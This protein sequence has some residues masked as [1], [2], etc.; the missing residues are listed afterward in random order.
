MEKRSSL[1]V[2]YLVM[3]LILVFIL[4]SYISPKINNVSYSQFKDLIVQKKINSVVVSSNSLRGFE[5]P[6]EGAKEPLFPKFAY[7]T[8]RV[9]DKDL[10][11]FLEQNKVD[12]IAENE[13][14]F[15][16][17][18]LSWVIPL[19]FFMLVWLWFMRR[20]GQ[21]GM[22]GIMTLGKSKAKI[23][24][25]RDVGITFDDVAGQDEAKQELMEILEFL[26]TPDKFTRLGARIPKGILLIGPPGTGKT[27]LAKAVAGESGVPF[28]S[29][30]GSDFIELFVGLGAARVRDLFEQAKL[31]AP[32]VI[33]IDELDALGKARGLGVMG[34]HDEREQTLNQLLAEMDGFAT[35]RG[36]IILAATNR[37]EILDPALLRPGRFDRQIL[38]DRPDLQGRIDILKIHTR[39]L[40]LAPGVD[41]EIIARRTSGFTGADLANLAN[42]AAL[43]TARKGKDR[44]GLQEIEEA[45]DRIIAGLEK[46][47]RHLNEKEKTIVAY[48]ETG[49]ALM[50]SSRPT[51]EKVHKIT[52]VPHGI[53]A[54]GFTL[55]LP[56]EDRYLMS[57]TE[58][59][60]KIDV[61]L[62][63]RA[64][65]EIIFGDVTTGAH[66]DLQKATD[67]ARS[68]VA[69]YGMNSALG[70]MTYQQPDNLFLQ[71]NGMYQPREISEQ[72]SRVI[73]EEVRKLIE[74]RMAEV[75]K[76]LC[77]QKGLLHF[78]AK[79][80]LE[81]ETLDSEEFK[82]LIKTGPGPDSSQAPEVPFVPVKDQCG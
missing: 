59:L 46:K 66:N 68:M 67:I 71:Q 80:L 12:I 55:Q 62:A 74:E 73:D 37:P 1:T 21:Q 39:Q 17:I 5:K 70:H 69:L 8:P 28:F 76:S 77:R 35:N 81:K 64:A 54:L 22:G 50:A 58:L 7:Q 72:T 78:V 33:F 9:D 16:R 29:I 25:Q 38:V 49:H 26:R 32:C 45:I 4:Q 44:V 6:S 56:T 57:R 79:R 10:I 20:L 52:I 82:E 43:L 13:N 30:T 63:G 40:V 31:V 75:K 60:E 3:A 48:H 61:L 24:A 27:L 65:E 18:F 2:V 14:T 15:W 11:S 41:L 19:G 47:N 42:E 53:A 23:I 51:A 36:V 34:G